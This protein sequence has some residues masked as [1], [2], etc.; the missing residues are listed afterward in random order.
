LFPP[1]RSCC[2]ENTEDLGA[3]N[4]LLSNEKNC[5][6]ESSLF[7][8]ERNCFA[9]DNGE[10][11]KFDFLNND[12]NA[13][14]PHPEA[15]ADRLRCADRPVLG[16]FPLYPPLELFASLGLL[17]IVLWGLNDIFKKI[18]HGDRHLQIF[19]CSVARFLA[20]FALSECAD[21]L[22]GFFMYNACD[23]LRNLPEILTAGL[24]Q[25]GRE[26][27]FFRMHIPMGDPHLP[28]NQEFLRNEIKNLIDNLENGFG[29]SFSEERFA[30]S[31]EQYGRVRDCMRQLELRTAAGEFSFQDFLNVMLATNFEPI[32]NQIVLLRRALSA[33]EN[34]PNSPNA[35]RHDGTL[36]TILSGILPP[37]PG[38]VRVLEDAG[39]VIAGNDIAFLSRS[40]AHTPKTRDV[41]SYYEDFYANHASCTTLLFSADRRIDFLGHL[42]NE[43]NAKSVIFIGEKFCEYEYFEFPFMRKK[44]AGFGIRSLFIEIG[45][46]GVESLEDIRTR[47]EAFSELLT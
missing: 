6:A 24:G 8:T 10:D 16:C 7:S 5:Y 9:E 4:S 46:E 19:V 35:A 11:R 15:L 43:R 31:A 29:V 14:P 20:E 34:A 17:P 23:S 13:I 25:R 39:F 2:Q 42:A 40:Y 38:L 32:E 30:E 27:P 45:A 33:N 3:E 12:M 28:K 36:R 47:I 26:Q 21:Y 22:R 1:K 37:P 18:Q 41:F 44:L